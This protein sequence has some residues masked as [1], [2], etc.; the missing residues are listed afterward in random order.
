MTV[1]I[2]TA[3]D[4]DRWRLYRQCCHSIMSTGTA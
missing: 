1:F 2:V 3:V 4:A